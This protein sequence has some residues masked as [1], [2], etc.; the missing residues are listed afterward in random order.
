[1]GLPVHL[2]G[3]AAAVDDLFGKAGDVVWVEDVVDA[4]VEAFADGTDLAV[5]GTVSGQLLRHLTP[6]WGLGRDHDGPAYRPEETVV[7]PQ[8][9]QP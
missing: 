5:D 2:D 9:G 8:P 4:D 1:M 6:K 7:Y 3:H